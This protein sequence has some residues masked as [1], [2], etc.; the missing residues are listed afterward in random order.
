MLFPP[1]AASTAHMSSCCINK[2][3]LMLSQ[4]SRIMTSSEATHR[5]PLNQVSQAFLFQIC[6]VSLHRDPTHVGIPA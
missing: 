3:E 6:E 2:M 1:N 4:N 5:N